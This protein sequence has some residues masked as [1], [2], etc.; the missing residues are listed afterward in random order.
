M[1]LSS[2]FLS[3]ILYYSADKLRTTACLSLCEPLYE[4][5][6]IPLICCHNQIFSCSARTRRTYFSADFERNNLFS[7]WMEE[8]K[9]II[10]AQIVNFAKYAYFKTQKLRESSVKPIW[11]FPFVLPVWF[12]IEVFTILNTYFR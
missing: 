1:R 10:K 7:Y 3:I 9:I 11:Q 2:N 8:K 12:C 4:K 5:P 6:Y